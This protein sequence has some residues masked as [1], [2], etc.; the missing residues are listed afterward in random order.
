MIIRSELKSVKSYLSWPPQPSDL[1]M[2]APLVKQL[3][4]IIIN[5]N[6]EAVSCQSE[7]LTPNVYLFAQD[8]IDAVSDGRCLTPKH[9]LFPL[10][11]KL[12]TRNVELIRIPNRLGHGVSYTRTL[13][14]DTA[15]ALEKMKI[16]SL[17]GVAIQRKYTNMFQLVLFLTTL[18]NRKRL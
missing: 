15:F 7:S 1:K 10:A 17:R 11:V 6:I 16:H 8:L 3:L 12:L 9:T 13:E 18:I 14:I 4:P 2:A 5:G